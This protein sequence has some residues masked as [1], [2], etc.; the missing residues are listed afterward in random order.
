MGLSTCHHLYENTA[1]L[2]V[3][4]SFSKTFFMNF[5][6]EVKSLEDCPAHWMK[7]LATLAD[8]KP[9]EPGVLRNSSCT[10]SGHDSELSVHPLKDPIADLQELHNLS[11]LMYESRRWQNDSSFLWL[12]VWLEC[13]HVPSNRTSLNQGWT[14]YTKGQ[15]IYHSLC[16]CYICGLAKWLQ[17][18]RAQHKPGLTNT[19][20]GEMLY[21]YSKGL[22][23]GV[24]TLAAATLT[25]C[26][27]KQVPGEQASSCTCTSPCTRTELGTTCE[28][29]GQF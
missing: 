22:P 26:L 18:Q 3:K 15:R 23:W 20:A 24:S 5:H 16:F 12:P 6:H 21:L 2:S 13:C 28:V 10:E 25:V 29:L 1:C 27:I 19:R 8:S 17:F 9:G 4:L 7:L 11:L 14:V